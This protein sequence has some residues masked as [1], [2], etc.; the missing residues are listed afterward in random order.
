MLISIF[1]IPNVRN[2]TAMLKI[3]NTH[4]KWTHNS[5]N[6]NINSPTCVHMSGYKLPITEQ[7][8]AQKGLA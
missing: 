5:L 2:P 7:N 1:I 4:E 8:F 3:R 6:F